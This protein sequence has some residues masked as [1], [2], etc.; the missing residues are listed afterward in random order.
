MYILLKEIL[1]FQSLHNSISNEFLLC[2][3]GTV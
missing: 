3:E 2:A 1:A